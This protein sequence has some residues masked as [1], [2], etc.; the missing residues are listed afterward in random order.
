MKRSALIGSR[1][2]L[3]QG[4]KYGFNSGLFSL[5]KGSVLLPKEEENTA[6]MRRKG[7][8]RTEETELLLGSVDRWFYAV[9]RCFG[10]SWLWRWWVVLVGV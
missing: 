5:M 7:W 6:Q 10:D 3:M 8:R 1:V 4:D 9:E 2:A